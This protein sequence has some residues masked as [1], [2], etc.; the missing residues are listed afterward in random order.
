MLAGRNPFLAESVIATIDRIRGFSP[1]PLH[2]VNREVPPRLARAIQRMIDKDPSNR[3]ASVSEISREL[4]SIQD[5]LPRFRATPPV[6]STRQARRC[7]CRRHHRGRRTAE[8]PEP[9]LGPPGSKVTLHAVN[10]DVKI[11]F[12]GGSPFKSRGPI[13]IAKHQSR[14]EEVGEKRGD[15]Q[16]KLSCKNPRCQTFVDNPKMIVP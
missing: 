9:H 14:V 5:Q 6:A 15:F 12:P 13:S 10:T 2:L 4:V 8:P 7:H 11:K 16:Y 3:Y 1:Q